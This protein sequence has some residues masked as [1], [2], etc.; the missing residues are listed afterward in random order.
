MKEFRIVFENKPAKLVELC[1]AL[2]RS[3]INIKSIVSESDDKVVRI[4]II[5]EDEKTTKEILEKKKIV[6]LKKVH[7][8]EKSR[9][10][11]IYALYLG[12][13]KAGVENT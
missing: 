10:R 3:G 2:S 8:S 5:T 11:R 9:V 1:E 7:E 4:H 6:K 12:G 13:I